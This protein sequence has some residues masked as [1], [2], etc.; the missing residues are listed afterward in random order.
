MTFGASNF[1]KLIP[2]QSAVYH[3]KLISTLS[4]LIGLT[5]KLLIKLII[6]AMHNIYS[7]LVLWT[8]R[9]RSTMNMVML[10][11]TL[12]AAV[13]A[14]H[15]I[16]NAAYSYLTI[17]CTG[18]GMSYFIPVISNVKIV[19]YQLHLCHNKRH[20]LIDMHPLTD[21]LYFLAGSSRSRK[22]SLR[23]YQP[24]KILV[25]H[26]SLKLKGSTFTWLICS[27]FSQMC[28]SLMPWSML[29]LV[30]FYILDI[31]I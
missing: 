17:T 18:H 2:L 30:L 19:E 4:K 26:I 1:Y 10:H 21:F 12:C 14:F 9:W 7:W 22:Q 8:N 25:L 31:L 11:C 20:L 5:I 3:V 15:G 27:R 29:L 28:G 6:Q 23:Y 24:F 16:V 13:T